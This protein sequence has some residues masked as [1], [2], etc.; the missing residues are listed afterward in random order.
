M[1]TVGNYRMHG[2]NC[3]TGVKTPEPPTEESDDLVK[4]LRPASGGPGGGGGDTGE[5]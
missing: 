4:L 5:A 2:D 3:N 1:W